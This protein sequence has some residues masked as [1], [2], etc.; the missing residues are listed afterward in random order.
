MTPTNT[1]PSPSDATTRPGKS[2][3]GTTRLPAAGTAGPARPPRSAARRGSPPAC[4]PAAPASRPPPTRRRPRRTQQQLARELG[5]TEASTARLVDELVEAGL[6]T[7]GQD[8]RDRRRYALELTGAGREHIPAMLA[9][10][11]QVEAGVRDLL[12]RGAQRELHGLLTR[13]LDAPAE[14]DDAGR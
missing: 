4:R 12:G 10:L 3:P 1:A 11:R 14:A 8:P 5:F 6:V 2:R 9:A 13:L 7:R